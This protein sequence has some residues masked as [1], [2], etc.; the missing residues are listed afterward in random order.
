MQRGKMTRYL[1]LLLQKIRFSE[2]CSKVNFLKSRGQVAH[3][4]CNRSA[5][6]S[7]QNKE[8]PDNRS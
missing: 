6:A 1:S 2:E 7:W 8:L 3:G 4:G 5:V